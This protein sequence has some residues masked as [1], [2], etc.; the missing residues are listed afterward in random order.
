MFKILYDILLALQVNNFDMSE[1]FSLKWN[2]FHTNVSKSFELLR[3]EEY[4]QDVTLV[5]DDDFQVKAHKIV[6]STSSSY[7]KRIFMKNFQSNILLCL[8]GTTKNDL[9]NIL[10]YIYL[11]EVQ[12]F[13]EDLDRFLTIAQRLKLEGL[14]EETIEQQF[15]EEKV[16]NTL[17]DQEFECQ[18]EIKRRPDFGRTISRDLT[19]VKDKITIPLSTEDKAAINDKIHEN[20]EKVLSGVFKCKICGKIAKQCGDI[21]KHVETHLE[22]L[23]Y[24]CQQ[25]G[26]TF[27]SADALRWHTFCKHK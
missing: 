21:K 9:Q 5:S 27:R 12:I 25:C 11:G 6:L 1:K 3:N 15:E 18:N 20:F 23:S 14:L 2:D 22:G 7:F 16:E 13:Q 19:N 26:K 10:D 24:P 4:L 17:I 8:E